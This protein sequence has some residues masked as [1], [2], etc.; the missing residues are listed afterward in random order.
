MVLCTVMVVQRVMPIHSSTLRVCG[1]TSAGSALASVRTYMSWFW[2]VGNCIV[3]VGL[4]PQPIMVEVPTPISRQASWWYPPFRPTG[5]MD[6]PFHS[7][8]ILPTSSGASI[9]PWPWDVCIFWCSWISVVCSSVFQ[10]RIVVM[11]VC[12]R[13]FCLNMN[14]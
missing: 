8:S 7:T 6:T 5:Q 11:A 13:R 10:R 12:L 9:N 2:S 3:V 14:V 1:R 4:T